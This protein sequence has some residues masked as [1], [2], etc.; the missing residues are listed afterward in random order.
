MLAFV[1]KDD[2]T[3]EE[4]IDQLRQ[5]YQVNYE[6]ATDEELNEF[7][8]K[9]YIVYRP[10]NVKTSLKKILKIFSE[11]WEEEEDVQNDEFEFT[12]EGLDMFSEN[13][14]NLID[15]LG[16]GLKDHITVTLT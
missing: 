9:E 3:E 11:H 2:Y 13:T 5:M 7:L 12:K 14:F 15:V 4:E 6:Q 10:G 16:D 8:S 1:N